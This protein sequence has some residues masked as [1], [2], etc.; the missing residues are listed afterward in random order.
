MASQ[1]QIFQHCLEEGALAAGPALDRCLVQA[2]AALQTA[3]TQSFRVVDRNAIAT[4][5]Q[6]L[7]RLKPGWLEHYPIELRAAFAGNEALV[8]HASRSSQLGSFDMPASASAP[9]FSASLS[10]PAPL[11]GNSAVDAFSL[12]DDAA[13]TQA[14]ASGRLLQQV[15][16]R[17]D[18]ELAELDALISSAQGLANVRPELNPLRPDVFLR[19]L[20]G[21]MVSAGADDTVVTH[22]VNYLAEPLGRELKLI[23]SKLIELLEHAHVQAA[24]YRVVPAPAGSERTRLGR[25]GMPSD[26]GKTL[27]AGH[28]G[29]ESQPAAQPSQ[30]AD[31]SNY[32]IKD[33]LF[34]EFLANGDSN[35]QHGLAPSYYESVEKELADLQAA[36][37][38]AAAPL[39]P[40]GS[41]P[42]AQL[43]SRPRRRTDGEHQGESVYQ[44][45]YRQQPAI[46]RSARIVDASSTLSSTVWGPY[47]RSRERAM[48]HT[49]LKK[50]ATRVG[51]VLG[52]EVVRKLVNQV[53]QDPRLLGA[54]REAIVALE[55]SLL[56]LAMVDPRF[57]S[58]EGHAGR[59]LMERVAQRSFKYNDEFSAEFQEFFQLVI[60][61]FNALNSSAIDDSAPF[62]LALAQLETTWDAQDENALH[63]RREVMQALRFAEDRQESADQ[64][65]FSLSAR[66]DLDGVPGMVLDFL[67]GPWALAMA[68]ARMV[69]QRNQVDPE[70][71][72]S[73]VPDLLWSVKREVTL[74]RPAKLIDMIPGLIDKL[75]SGLALLGQDPKE[76]EIFFE[77]LLELH[78]PVL[79]LRRL[80][81]QR[82]TEESGVMPL[83]ALLPEDLP[84]TPEQRRAKAAEQPWLAREELDAAGFE[85]TQPTAPADLAAME[86]EME[87]SWHLQ[88]VVQNG[89]AHTEE[90][91]AGE[92]AGADSQV[93]ALAVDEVSSAPAQPQ[94][95]LDRPE[96]GED[97]PQRG[98]ASLPYKPINEATSPEEN[99]NA[100]Q[101]AKV[102]AEATLSSLNAG[103]WVD[104]YSKRRWLRAQLIWASS[105][106]TLF[107]FLS[108]GGQPHS[109]TR[110][111]CEKLIMQRLLRPVDTQG[112]IAQALDAV[113]QQAAYPT[114]S[115]KNLSVNSAYVQIDLPEGHD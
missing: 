20:Q 110:R 13:L 88:S 58:D 76:N 42:D 44:S 14:I 53:A 79:R 61:A 95:L 47:G 75:K 83:E 37:E 19:V 91:G 12:V 40:T 38:S 62:A 5:W 67:F 9:L 11:N 77:S 26:V 64:V 34:Q 57:F 36:P 51:Q 7:Y 93:D 72:G 105:K 56:R 106:G 94:Q 86:E 90:A 115:I 17:V 107:M 50:E 30:Y 100:A 82:D 54:V 46:D 74:K 112:V 84:A 4:A 39:A 22:W 10:R 6:Q 98:Q 80:K 18:R 48:V 43:M 114:P 63:R 1:H 92:A 16:P 35:A 108:H 29:P 81:T 31:L 41:R 49:Q 52:L 111:S 2:I 25:P 8:G 68:H 21:L 113:A 109:M 89:V 96:D 66:S 27:D 32:E 78:Q 28:C 45:D 60:D 87:S 59:Q 101:Q 102:Q 70:G 69:D 55:P 71:F 85:D 97:E 99:D 24:Q 33:E 3:E 104:L 73:V 103:H 23:Y 15:L 65:A